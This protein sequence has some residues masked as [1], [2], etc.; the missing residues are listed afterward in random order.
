MLSNELIL[1]FV[2]YTISLHELGAEKAITSS[3][4]RR[5]RQM[6]SVNRFIRLLHKYCFI[7]RKKLDHTEVSKSRDQQSTKAVGETEMK[8]RTR[9]IF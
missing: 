1:L 7:I 8:V 6:C 3:L 5:R 2:S 4:K 9:L